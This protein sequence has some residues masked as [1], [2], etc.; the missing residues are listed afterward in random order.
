MKP[1]SIVLLFTALSL[2]G[3]SDPVEEAPPSRQGGT[4]KLLIPEQGAY[5][6]AYIDAGESEDDVTIEGIE[7]FEKLV[8]KQQAIIA[9]SSYWG[10]QTFPRRNMEIISRHGSVPLL[11]WS[12]WDKPYLQDLGPDRFNLFAILAGRW[13][14]YID[15]WAD[16]A[17]AFGK[18]LFVAWGIEMNGTWFPWS[19]FFYGGDQK[20]NGTGDFL[21]PDTYKR[22][23]RYIV[24][25]VRAR[26][27]SNILWVFHANNYSYPVD[28]WN[29]I[30]SYYP[31]SDY[32]DWLGISAYGTQFHFQDWVY[33][34]DVFNVPYQALCAVDP[35]KPIMFAEWGVADLPQKGNRAEW[36]TESFNMLS[37]KYPRM[38]AA[39]FWHERWKNQDGSYSNLRVTSSNEVLK[40]YQKGVASPFWL[41]SPIWEK[42]PAP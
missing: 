38:K 37:T 5:T 22:T 3:C 7:D 34:K 17:K 13:D 27:A 9:S 30:Q 18:P 6:G 12:P 32:V 33:P 11:F 40:A 10:E 31:G 25:R 14:D 19:G 21:G 35:N 23:Y 41:S 29:T 24:D 2:A 20:L 26:G 39:I 16:E 4:G 36:I 15:K 8:G 1:F 28:P 42:K